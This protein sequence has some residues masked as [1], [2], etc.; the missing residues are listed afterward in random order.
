M[1]QKIL[2]LFIGSVIPLLMLEVT[3]RILSNYSY[4][5]RRLTFYKFDNPQFDHINSLESLLKNAPSPL[6]PNENWGGFILNSKGFRTPEYQLNKSPNMIRIIAI[7]DSMT[8]SSAV[9]YPYHFT[10]LLEKKSK[11]WLKN[12]SFE[13]INLGVPGVGLNMSK[14]YLK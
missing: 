3:I 8:F 4:G 12:K 5:I 7:G 11:T 1:K 10:V 2:A 14:R 13:L 6:K 9:P